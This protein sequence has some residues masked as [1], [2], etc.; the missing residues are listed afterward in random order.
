M[1]FQSIRFLKA[2]PEILCIEISSWKINPW[3]NLKQ[4]DSAGRLVMQLYCTHSI[5]GFSIMAR[6]HV[7]RNVKSK[8]FH[9]QNG[10]STLFHDG[11]SYLK[12]DQCNVHVNTQHSATPPVSVQSSDFRKES[13]TITH[14]F[15]PIMFTAMLSPGPTW[16]HVWPSWVWCVMHLIILHGSGRWWLMTP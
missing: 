3:S 7:M 10:R 13:V 1:F 14:I 6:L 11:Q 15:P 9:S 12:Y 8:Y 4:L 16:A 2:W 5:T